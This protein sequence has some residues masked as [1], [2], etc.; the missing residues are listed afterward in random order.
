MVGVLTGMQKLA[1]CSV[2][3]NNFKDTVLKTCGHIFCRVCI[4]DRIA[5]RMRKCPNCS[6]AFDRVDFMSVHL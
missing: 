6:K 2:C 4:D 1:T 3:Q 5:N